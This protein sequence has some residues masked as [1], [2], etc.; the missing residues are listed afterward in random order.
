MLPSIEQGMSRARAEVEM[1]PQRNALAK[2]L[3]QVRRRRNKSH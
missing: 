2:S 3:A 1:K